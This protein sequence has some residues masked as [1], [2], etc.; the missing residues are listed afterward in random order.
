MPQNVYSKLFP[1]GS[2]T[3]KFYGTAKMHKLLTNNIDDFPP[4]PIMSNIKTATYQ[5]E[6]YLAKLLS[7]LGSSEYT[8]SNIKTSV[9][10]I[11]KMKVPLVYK[12]I[13]FDVTSCFTNASLDKT[14]EI[15][16]KKYNKKIEISTTIPKLEMKELLYICTKNVYFLFN[17]EIYMQND[18]VAL[19]SPLGLVFANIVM[20]VL[21]R[22]IIP[23]LSNKHWKSCVDD[24][25]AL[26][27]EAISTTVYRKVTDTY[28][29]INWQSVSPN[30]WKWRTFQT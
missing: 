11:R 13:S 18:G 21:E 23:S 7:P 22:T 2:S 3:G 28:I 5:T 26:K 4:R 15:I 16:F 25:I 30:N 8:I 29:Y 20:V 10:Q 24:I 19:G 6:K 12:M 9:K 17:S 14:L 27:I 1:S